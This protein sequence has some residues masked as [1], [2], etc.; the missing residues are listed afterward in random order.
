MFEKVLKQLSYLDFEVLAYHMKEEKC[1]SVAHL[2]DK[3]A[4]RYTREDLLRI[5]DDL[6]YAYESRA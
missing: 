3:L 5:V 6:C 4:Y 2:A 1:K